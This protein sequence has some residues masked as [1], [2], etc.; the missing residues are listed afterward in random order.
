MIHVNIFHAGIIHIKTGSEFKKCCDPA[1]DIYASGGSLDYSGDDLKDRGFTGT[2]SSYNAHHLTLFDLKRYIINIH[3]AA[4]VLHDCPD[5]EALRL[6][7]QLL[8]LISPA[9]L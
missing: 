5:T 3:I 6:K 9:P 8:F 2:I 7:R 1:V 4:P